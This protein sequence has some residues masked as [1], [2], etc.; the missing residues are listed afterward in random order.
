MFIEFSVTLN[1]VICP[2]GSALTALR[3]F[4]IPIVGLIW[5]TGLSESPDVGL[6]VASRLPCAGSHTQPPFEEPFPVK[7]RVRAG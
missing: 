5:E 4:G 3:T 7:S 6:V 2:E 1:P